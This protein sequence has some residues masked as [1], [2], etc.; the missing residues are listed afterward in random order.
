MFFVGC[1]E[2]QTTLRETRCTFRDGTKTTATENRINELVSR[3]S[4]FRLTKQWYDYAGCGGT[5]FR[6]RSGES[7][8]LLRLDWELGCE[9]N[10][11]IS[12][13]VLADIDDN[14]SRRG[15]WTKR[16]CR[17]RTANRCSGYQIRF[18]GFSSAWRSENQHYFIEIRTRA[19]ESW[20]CRSQRSRLWQLD[21][22]YRAV[23][24]WI[25]WRFMGLQNSCSGCTLLNSLR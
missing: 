23:F 4:L 11:I 16:L 15:C 14:F 3:V 10:G 17:V 8:E 7:I 21:R 5:L 13:S 19:W 24:C 2:N 6:E 9:L 22:E 20:R 18:H 1:L 12:S 25:D